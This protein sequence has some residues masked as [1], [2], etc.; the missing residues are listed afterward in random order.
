MVSNLKVSDDLKHQLELRSN[1]TGIS[2]LDLVNKYIS[3]GL[4][5]DKSK[6]H[7]SKEEINKLLTH[8]NP[9]GRSS[10]DGMKGI[11]DLGYKTDA[12]HLKKESY[13][14]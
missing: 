2:Q 7:M 5:E 14:R 9:S 13:K 4:K 6:K 11:I 3:K 8:D 1:E 10:L 12:I